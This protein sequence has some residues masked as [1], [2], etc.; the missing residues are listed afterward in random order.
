MRNGQSWFDPLHTKVKSYKAVA[1]AGNELVQG[2]YKAETFPV[3]LEKEYIV[4]E[5]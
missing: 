5:V 2:P 4:V 1:S 3:M